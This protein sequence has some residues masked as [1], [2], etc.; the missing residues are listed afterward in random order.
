MNKD[1]NLKG[2][3]IIIGSLLWEDRLNLDD[4]NDIRKEWRNKNL[5]E[6]S[7]TMVKLP[8]RYGRYSNDRIYTMVF[9]NDCQKDKKLGTGYI[10]PFKSK[11]PIRDIGALLSK[12]KAMSKAEGLDKNLEKDWGKIAI[13]FNPDKIN[14]E[15]KKQILLEWSKQSE[16]KKGSW[17]NY[18]LGEEEPC[19]NSNSELNIKWP[20]PVD[21]QK[22]EVLSQL[23][24]LIAAVTKPKHKNKT[25]ITYPTDCE[26]AETVKKDKSRF[27]FINSIKHY[28]TTF[29]DN[30][31]LNKIKP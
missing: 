29:Q 6:K 24:F 19:I 12:A 26:I 1:W 23:D 7:K 17:K 22:T 13:L 30:A 27:Y 25:T 9:S 2:G 28:I 15:I 10:F 20:D 18:K 11:P 31:I 5:N 21:N 3:V 4:Q 14:P 8:I 16:I